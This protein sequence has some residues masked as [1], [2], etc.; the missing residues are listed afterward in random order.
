MLNESGYF[1]SDQWLDGA[2]A[3]VDKLGDGVIDGAGFDVLQ[4]QL[5]E[6]W[7]ELDRAEAFEILHDKMGF[8]INSE[9]LD[10]VWSIIDAN[11]DGVLRRSL[12][13]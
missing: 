5:Q 12:P 11:N 3:T 13:P 1:P 6:A 9:W 2:W 4:T 10:G 7:T 8:D